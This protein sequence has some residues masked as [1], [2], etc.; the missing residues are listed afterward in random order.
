M[1]GSAEQLERH[2]EGPVPGTAEGKTTTTTS[3][4]TTCMLKAVTRTTKW[5]GGPLTLPNASLSARRSW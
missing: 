2:S 1:L 4:E 3:V 5:H